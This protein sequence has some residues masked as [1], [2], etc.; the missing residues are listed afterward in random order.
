MDHTNKQFWH[1]QVEEMYAKEDGG[2]HS[3]QNEEDEQNLNNNARTAH[4]CKYPD[5]DKA[6][7]LETKFI[8]T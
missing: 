6:T 3:K 8:N 4:H 1:F 2:N 7:Y 5:I